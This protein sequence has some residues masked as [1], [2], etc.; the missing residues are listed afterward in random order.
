MFFFSFSYQIASFRPPLLN[1]LCPVDYTTKPVTMKV[2]H[3]EV[4]SF[5][6]QMI[7]TVEK[8]PDFAPTL[9]VNSQLLQGTS[10]HSLDN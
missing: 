4:N 8:I 9:H 7:N 10:P 6:V 2:N 5:L 1:L 3:E